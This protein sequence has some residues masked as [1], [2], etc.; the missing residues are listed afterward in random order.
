MDNTQKALGALAIVGGLYLLLKGKGGTQPP[1]PPPPPGLATVRVTVVNS[2]GAP[3]AGASV[4]L[5][6]LQGS[7]SS[8][9]VIDFT[10][11]ELGSY[12]LNVTAAG[13]QPKSQAVTV[14]EGTNS[15]RVELIRLAPAVVTIT[16]ALTNYPAGSFEYDASLLNGTGWDNVR[17]SQQVTLSGPAQTTLLVKIYDE[18]GA[19]IYF[20]QVEVTLEDGA[21]YLFDCVAKQLL[22]Q[23]L[24]W[25][26]LAINIPAQVSYAGEFMPRASLRLASGRLLYRFR[27][28]IEYGGRNI[29]FMGWSFL[30]SEFY[31]VTKV[32]GSYRPLD[33]S[34]NL[35]TIEGCNGGADLPQ[36]VSVPCTLYYRDRYRR[37]WPVPIGRYPVYAEM[38]W[39]PVIVSEGDIA[40]TEPRL[41]EDLGQVATLEVV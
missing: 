13:Y 7:T 41:T 35:Y 40:T 16:L 32:R 21:F 33:A 20:E 8:A 24:P 37:V 31:A 26:V 10:S 17:I 2:S 11:V 36:W 23:E 28:W 5:D 14:L 19:T 12:L 29:P 18:A 25:S 27:C 34:D 3:I 1:P 39:A 30:P 6:S 38:F 15:F 9:G 4:S 22:K